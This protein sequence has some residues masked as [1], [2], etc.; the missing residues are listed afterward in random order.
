MSKQSTHTPGPWFVRN[1]SDT[2]AEKFTIEKVTD[3]LRSV[4]CQLNDTWVCPEHGGTG[5][6]ANA[7][8]IVRACNSHAALVEALKATLTPLV[9]LGDFIG[10][11]DKGGASGLGAFD[12]CA[13]IGKVKEALALAEGKE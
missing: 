12:R 6:D 4:I 7:A 2:F 9:R 3:G 1:M 5:S 11:E 13:I 8:F 10:N